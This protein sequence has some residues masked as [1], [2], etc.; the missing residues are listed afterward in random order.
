VYDLTRHP[1]FT[2]LALRARDEGSAELTTTLRQLVGQRYDTVLESR[3]VPP[4]AAV[5]RHY[6]VDERD[7]FYLLRP[8]GYVAFRCAVGE[9][10]ALSAYLDDLFT[11]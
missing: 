11:I 8:D 1:R 6:G 7:R 5:T 9:A 10:A 2:L 3:V 4:T